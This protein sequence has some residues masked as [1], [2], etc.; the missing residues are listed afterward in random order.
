V[1]ALLELL[2]ATLAPVDLDQ[3]DPAHRGEQ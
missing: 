3:R 1:P 2:Q